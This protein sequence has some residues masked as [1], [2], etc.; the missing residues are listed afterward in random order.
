MN[1]QP[2]PE[3]RSNRWRWILGIA[4]IG[5]LFFVFAAIA[6]LLT[7]DISRL[8][9]LFIQVVKQETGR[10]LDIHG[11]MDF[12]L[13]LR[14]SL[15]LDD[16]VFQN[17]P[18]AAIP[19]MIKIKRLEAKI[20]ALPLLNKEIQIT[21]LVLVEPEVLIERD[22]SGKWNF[23]FEKAAESPRKEAHPKSFSLPR[24]AFHEVRVEKGRMSFRDADRGILCCFSIER[25]SATSEGLEHPIAIAFSGSYNEN[26]LE[27]RGTVGSLALLKGQVKD[28][29]VD[30]IA[31]AAGVQLKVEGTIHDILS[32]R[33]LALKAVAEIQSTSQM[34]GFFSKSPSVELGPLQARA[35]VSDEEGGKA[36]RL[37]DLK[38]MSKAGG[39]EGM[40]MVSLGG[41][42]P[43]LTG[44]VSLQELNLNPFLNGEKSKRAATEKASAQSRVFPNAPLPLPILNSMD[45][46]VKVDIK[47]L[48][49]THLPL[50]N[51]ST[52]VTGDG[53][54]LTLNPI[55]LKAAGG[56]AEGQMD[57]RI[58]GKVATVKTFFKASQI[59]L[60]LLSPELRAEGKMD[61][62]LDLL[63]RGSSIAGLMAGLNGRTV[64]VLGQGRV[65][66]KTIQVLGGELASEIFQLFNPSSKATDH[67]D[68]NCAVSGFD[69]KDGMAKVTAL[70]VDTP[71]MTVVGEGEVSLRDETLDLA[72]KPYEK[73]GAAGLNLSL[74]ELAKSFR[75][76]GTLA[77][78]S[79]QLDAAQ[80][81]LTAG[82]AAGG[83]LLFGPAG[84]ATA[85]AGQSSG[86]GNPCLTA[87]EAAK[88]GLSTSESGKGGE[89]KRTEEKGLPGTLKGVGET[90]KKLFSGQGTPQ[91]SDKRSIPY[92]GG[93]N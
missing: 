93:E 73:G 61:A 45:L 74:G 81:M 84:I 35:L 64:V 37:S 4:A 8:K 19:E 40:L 76:G 75:L 57:V 89:Q 5:V 80:T 46:K 85:L 69:I 68:V 43:K 82:K 54:R 16:V 53:T 7:L 31:N 28:Y 26:P 70:V 38:I 72:L 48:Q 49:W 60:R 58:S 33:G 52:E 39:V 71:D 2:S 11:A 77:D 36:Y 65:D 9:P 13:G 67:T 90:V 87:L 25:F 78:P 34:S 41:G 30:V 21:R 29:P 44:S 66:N 59:D 55:K 51:M 27:L 42:R 24:L 1:E 17:A 79:L 86:E 14:P 22:S 23:E 47:R 12:K 63:T 3:R 15:V 32:F 91:Q 50:E 20:L 92:R 10:N 6:I 83:V 62:D 88:K 56:D 18:D